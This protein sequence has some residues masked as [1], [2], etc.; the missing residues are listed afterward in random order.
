MPTDAWSGL[1]T[2][3]VRRLTAEL[4]RVEARVAAQKMAAVRALESSGAARKAGA[5]STG[6]LLA[7]DFGGDEAA[8]HRLVKTAQK[9]ESTTHTQDAL[10]RG[11]VTFEQ[12][13]VI[14]KGLDKLP[15][16]VTVQQ[17]DL[18]E[19]TLLKDAERLTIKDLRRR[20]DRLMDVYAAKPDVDAHENELLV[21]RERLA[22]QNAYFRM[23]DEKNGMFRGEF[24][25][26]EAEAVMLKTAVDAL[27]A[28]S[29]A[30][31]SDPDATLGPVPEDSETDPAKKMGRAF[32]DL[33]SHLPI[34]QLP[35]NGGVGA[36]VVVTLEHDTLVGG[37]A[38]AT[39]S[40]G[41]RLSASQARKLACRVGIIPMVLDGKPLP[42]DYGQSK[43][44]FEKYQR[45]GLANR[46]G[47]C[48][49]PT[50]DRPPEWTEAHHLTPYS[51]GG[52]TN[53]QDG[54]LLCTRHHHHVHDTHWESR[55]A[56]DGHIEWRPP[57][58]TSWQRNPRNRA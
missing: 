25:L 36:Q 43:R 11:E 31:L 52:K 38:P 1:E 32:T 27:A 5:T 6:N 53:L 55:T 45:I 17:R 15:A 21:H 3:E 16:D 40:D 2:S 9:L 50:C 56:P 39:L 29:R 26:P 10:A 30:H 37:I 19:R 34:D 18:A 12:S 14:A 58:T 35:S 47:G 7:R 33:C 51:V 13:S 22:R 24:E 4:T 28:P 42:L 44:Y 54:T 8:G 49:F 48:S 41:T 46:D 57:G 23:W 20:T